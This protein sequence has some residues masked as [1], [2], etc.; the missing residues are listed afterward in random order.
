MC[1][2]L[3]EA[4]T[5]NFEKYGVTENFSLEYAYLSIPIVIGSYL[6]LSEK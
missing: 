3:F 6:F 1:Y 4:S 5:G 2:F